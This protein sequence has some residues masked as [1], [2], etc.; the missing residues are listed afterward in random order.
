MRLLKKE[1]LEKVLKRQAELAQATRKVILA[2]GLKI[3]GENP[4]NVVISAL[5]MTLLEL[6]YS[7]ELGKGLKAAGE[8]FLISDPLAK[9]GINRFRK[10]KN[11]EV[12]HRFSSSLKDSR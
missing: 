2:M 10:E 6:N 12:T 11:F 3:F 9:E 1:G 7:V 4:S 8:V 5:E